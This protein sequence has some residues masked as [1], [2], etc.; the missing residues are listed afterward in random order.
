LSIDKNWPQDTTEE[1][2]D[3]LLTQVSE[4]KAYS[5]FCLKADGIDLGQVNMI[6][7]V[8][9]NKLIELSL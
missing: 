3:Y 1:R 5:K 8:Q 4:S 9:L 7:A 6:D 2:F